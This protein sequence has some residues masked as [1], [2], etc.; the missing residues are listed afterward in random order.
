M[1]PEKTQALQELLDESQYFKQ[2]LF[3]EARR[4]IMMDYMA[5]RDAFLD[6]GE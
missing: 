4:V 5:S 3:N 6:V 2:Q 1:L